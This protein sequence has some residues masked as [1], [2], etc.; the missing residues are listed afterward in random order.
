MNIDLSVLDHTT[1]SHRNQTLKKYGQINI[2]SRA[3]T[4][5]SSTD[6]A[7]LRQRN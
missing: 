6:E 3:N 2:H 7:T 5:I 4:V 1:L